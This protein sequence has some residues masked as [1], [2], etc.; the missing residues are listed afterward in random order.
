MKN[1]LLFIGLLVASLFIGSCSKNTEVAPKPSLVGVWKYKTARIPYEDA[2]GKT[3]TVDVTAKASTGV[4]FKTSDY[5]ITGSNQP[6]TVT[7]LGQSTTV[8]IKNSTYKISTVDE[9]VV[10]I[11]KVAGFNATEKK[12]FEDG[13]AVIKKEGITYVATIGDFTLI[14]KDATSTFSIQWDWFSIRSI[15]TSQMVLELFGDDSPAA[16]RFQI[17]LEK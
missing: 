10:E 14:G 15:T 1:S 6:F 12:A 8:Q 16:E 7:K 3:L 13:V 17:T 4:E 2:T 11:E 9:I 5:V